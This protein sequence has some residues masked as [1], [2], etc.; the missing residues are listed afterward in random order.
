MQPKILVSLSLLR[1]RLAHSNYLRS[2]ALPLKTTTILPHA[3]P[4]SKMVSPLKRKAVLTTSPKSKKA[5]VEIPEYHLA[6]SRRDS[7]GEIIWPAPLPQINRARDIITECAQSQLPTLILPDKD[8]DG[9]SSGTILHHTLTSLGLSPALISVYFPPKGSSIFDN[10]T[11]A[12]ITAKSPSYIF[13][14]DQ[15]SRKSPAFL[16]DAPHKCLTLIIDHHFAAEGGFPDGAD[17]VTAH[18]CP[19]VATSSLLTY[20]ICQPLYQSPD[21]K[22]SWLAALGTHGDLGTTLRWQPPFPDMTSTFKTYSKKSI[23][24]A[25]ALVNAP[26]RAPA[27]NVSAA[28]D[29]VLAATSPDVINQ[30]TDLERAAGE[31]RYETERCTHT[32]PKFS[33]DASIAVLTISSAAQVHPIIATRWAGHLKSD[34]L[35]IVMC[36]NEGYLEGMVNFS[37]RVARGARAKEGEEKVDI[38]RKLER[39]VEGEGELRERLGDNFARG[40]REASGGI[41]KKEDWEEL[42]R[43]MGIGENQRKKAEGGKKKESKP[44]QKNTLANYF[45]KA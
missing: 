14:L 28:W 8:A 17:Y 20:H 27:Y 23:N 39:I 43:L 18:D 15:G 9:L 5:K 38:I 33:A 44:A 25:V 21:D 45:V 19:P 6:P 24:T 36:A 11:R 42:K 13:V 10:S 26:R 41:V 12:T 30:S 32:A 7:A 2:K 29:V 34:K 37:C 31:V 1:L 16:G 40:H 22:L 35:E 3:H 4:Y